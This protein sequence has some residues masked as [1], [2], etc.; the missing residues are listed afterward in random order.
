MSGSLCHSPSG[1]PSENV[2]NWSKSVVTKSSTTGAGVSRVGGGAVINVY[3]SNG[4]NA[5][6]DK[7]RN[8]YGLN[9]C[10]KFKETLD[11]F[12]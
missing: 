6:F 10:Q 7:R 11:S 8:L 2:L 1:T 3:T 5:N 4:I 9:F 12:V